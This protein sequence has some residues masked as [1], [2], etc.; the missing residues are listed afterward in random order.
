MTRPGIE[1]RSPEPLANTLNIMS[2][3]HII[4][5]YINLYISKRLYI[6]HIIHIY[7]NLSIYLYIYIY[8]YII[9]IYIYIKSILSIYF[10]IYIYISSI[11]SIY[12]KNYTYL[13]Y[14]Q[15]K[16]G[17]LLVENYELSQD[18][19]AKVKRLT[20]K[21]MWISTLMQM[22]H[23]MS[24]KWATLKNIL[25]WGC[26]SKLIS[27]SWNPRKILYLFRSWEKPQNWILFVITM[28]PMI[29]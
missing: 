29:A 22:Y 2:I 28:P 16:K 19:K 20:G 15:I 24:A 7:Q 8:I 13:P 6:I 3:T 14:Y 25:R 23:L 5:I 18:Q 17:R 27:Q 21:I 10:K 12:I 1:L 26:S 11:L 4:Y 9:Y